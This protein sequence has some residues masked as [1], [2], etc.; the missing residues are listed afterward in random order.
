MDI[1]FYGP[2]MA[3]E[4]GMRAFA[5]ICQIAEFGAS[6]DKNWE[7]LGY[8]CP[9]NSL[10][11]S[12]FPNERY[13]KSKILYEELLDTIVSAGL[14]KINEGKSSIEEYLKYHNQQLRNKDIRNSLVRI[15]GE[16]LQR[17]ISNKGIADRF[18]KAGLSTDDAKRLDNVLE[19][20]YYSYS[21]MFSIMFKDFEK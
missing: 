16:R 13:K 15:D 20:I 14:L 11:S 6:D 8:S 10:V 3:T 5:Q 9:K 12:L 19:M 2:I 7:A 18:E 17:M 21:E 4:K 1:E